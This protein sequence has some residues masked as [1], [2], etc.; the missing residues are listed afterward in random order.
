MKKLSTGL[1]FFIAIFLLSKETIAQFKVTGQYR[2]RFEYRDGF[3][4]PADSLTQGVGFVDQR[5][6]L[7]FGYNNDSYE[8]YL[9]LQDIRVWGNTSQL[10]RSDGYSSVHQAW[11]RVKL[12]QKWGLKLGRQE[13]ILDDH[14][15]F[16]NV[17][18]ATQ[19][20]SHDA[21]MIMYSDS[22]FQ[23][24]LSVAYNAAGPSVFNQYYGVAKSYKSFQFLWLHKDFGES[25]DASFL[26]LN[27]G[28]QVA[29][30][31][32]AAGNVIHWKDNYSQ[33]AGTRLTFKSDMID[34]RLNFYY[35]FGTAPDAANSQINALNINPEIA[36]K[37]TKKLKFVLGYEYL[38]G[39]SQT[40]TTRAYTDVNHAFNP[41]YGTNHKFNGHMDYFYV[42]NHI[43][44]VGLQDAYLKIQY[45]TKK[46]N[47]GVDG[48]YFMS[49]ADVLDVE[50]QTKTGNIQAMD[51]GLGI[52]FDLYGGFKIVDAVSMKLG[53]SYMANTETMIAVKGSGQTSEPSYWGWA[54]VI[55][56]PTLF[57]SATK[58]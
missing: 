27:N 18:W 28:I 4:Q 31:T 24:K 20:R 50:E 33:T 9:S 21:A 26:F 44:N 32:D 51:P 53:L 22:T 40:D 10:N 17:D 37:A 34:A 41:F 43:N 57:D 13:I 47:V 11:A 58:K 25:L 35:Q 46:F 52:E 49:A 23:A 7:N 56:K 45:K 38:S 29:T 39:Q 1:T 30:G 48:H 42:G 19:A 14:R 15:I 8:F 6:R 55:I 12:N 16:G 2:P 5:T 36:F 54:M 3:Y